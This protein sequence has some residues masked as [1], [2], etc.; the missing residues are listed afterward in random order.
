MK[1]SAY[2]VK[3]D[4]HSYMDLFKEKA[5]FTPYDISKD[6]NFG[7]FV[8]LGVCK[9][10][11]PEWLKLIR[12]AICDIPEE[13]QNKSTRAVIIVSVEDYYIIYAL[14]HGRHLINDDLIIRDFGIKIALNHIDPKK[15]KG[16]DK[17]SISENMIQQK[18]Q[19]ARSTRVIDFQIDKD[20]DFIRTIAGETI[21]DIISKRLHGSD[22]IQFNI[23]LEFSDLFELS[24]KLLSSYHSHEYK[25][26]FS[27]F[28]NMA[29]VKNKSKIKELD[30]LMINKLNANNQVYLAAPE[31]IDDF[32]V[33]KM[34]M[35]EH[36]D[37][38]DFDLDSVLGFYKSRNLSISVEILRKRYLYIYSDIDIEYNKKWR[39]Y[40][41]ILAEVECEDGYL[42]SLMMGI[43]FK[44]KPDYREAVQNFVESLDES[45]VDL[46]NAVRGERESKYN[47]D[48][49]K[50][51]NR[52][53][54]MD[55]KYGDEAERIEFCDLLTLDKQM[56]HVK[57]WKSSS[58]LSH[59]F[60][61]GR[62]ASTLLIEDREFRMK[63]KDKINS[64]NPQFNII[65]DGIIDPSTYEI[66]YAII[67]KE[68]LPISKRLPFFSKVNLMH[69]TKSLQNMR[70][71]VTLKHIKL[72]E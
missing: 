15:L 60:S 8:A 27:W 35:T 41:C 22:S 24:S 16:L 57:P 21:N 7:V 55:M 14:G 12:P 51:N 28:D 33:E 64:L 36:G 39:L 34:T 3:K 50:Y 13:Y 46:P 63:I 1:V 59:L 71:N 30:L 67:Y 69:S 25:N 32:Y 45:T 19:S 70:F 17:L 47:E 31:I 23:D 72:D 52:V 61:Q 38:L 68:N 10:N 49:P 11:E 53:L 29:I 66:V 9:E 48:V 4:N 37:I 40:N 6:F 56:I 5:K 65:E 18:M 43:W 62:I 20:K 2:L 54:T 42:Y 44:I 58:T 26:H